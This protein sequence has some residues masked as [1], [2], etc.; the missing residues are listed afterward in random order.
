V[1]A[2]NFFELERDVHLDEKPHSNF[3]STAVED[4]A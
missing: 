3:T 2:V 1:C 4:V